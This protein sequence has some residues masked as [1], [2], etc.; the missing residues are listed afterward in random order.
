MKD[1]DESKE[2]HALLTFINEA[3]SLFDELHLCAQYRAGKKTAGAGLFASLIDS[4]KDDY[5]RGSLIG[6][7][8]LGRLYLNLFFMKEKSLVMN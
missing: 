5:K 6:E 7:S 4:R 3:I 1:N 8:F 2:S